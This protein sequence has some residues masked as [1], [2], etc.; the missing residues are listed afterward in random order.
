MNQP[1]IEILENQRLELEQLHRDLG[2][3]QDYLDRGHLTSDKQEEIKSW[4]G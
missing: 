3:R 4:F 2:S 1:A